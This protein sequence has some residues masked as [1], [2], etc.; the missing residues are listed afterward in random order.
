MTTIIKRT[1]SL[2]ADQTSYIDDKV[3]AGEFASASE[4]VRAGLRSLRERDTAVEH[5][6]QAEVVKTYDAMKLDPTR[7]VPVEQAFAYV[8]ALH[9]RRLMDLP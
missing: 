7:G 2:P 1:I 4:V 8:R 9:A 3:K 6:L 5:W